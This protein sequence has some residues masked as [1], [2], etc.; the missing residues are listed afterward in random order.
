[1]DEDYKLAMAAS[2]EKYTS[3][4]VALYSDSD[5][6]Y[7]SEFKDY[8]ELILEHYRDEAEKIRWEYFNAL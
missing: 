6:M 7:L 2:K 5:K 4:I 8:V 3:R 1:M